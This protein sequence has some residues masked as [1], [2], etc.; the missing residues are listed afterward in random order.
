LLYTRFDAIVSSYLGETAANLRKVFDYAENGKWVILFDEFDAI[1]KARDDVSEH[2]ELKRVINSFLQ[3]LDGFTSHSIL[4]AA[5]NHQQLLDPALWRRFDEILNFP[6]PNQ[7]EIQNLI[8]MKLRNFPRRGLNLRTIAS[9]LKGMSHSDVERICF[10]A[11]KGAI[12]NDMDTLD[13]KTFEQA[14]ETHRGRVSIT[15]AA[16]RRR[17]N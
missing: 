3:L 8:E 7:K 17:K 16:E 6:L 5:T 13:S 9:R 4:V 10:D 12:L 15:K 14:L 1:G 11:L 2:G